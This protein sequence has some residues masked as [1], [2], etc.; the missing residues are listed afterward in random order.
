MGMGRVFVV[1][2]SSKTD[3]LKA[4]ERSRGITMDGWIYEGKTLLLCLSLR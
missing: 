4:F 3:V 2:V 1:V